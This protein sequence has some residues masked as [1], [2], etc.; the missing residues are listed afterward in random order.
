M[1]LTNILK[2]FK[3][4]WIIVEIIKHAIINDIIFYKWLKNNYKDLYKLKNKILSGLKVSTAFS[5]LSIY[6]SFHLKYKGLVRKKL[7]LM[8]NVL[9]VINFLKKWFYQRRKF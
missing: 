5:I 6:D 7:L 8:Y 1:L 3:I 2:S 4:I 9:K